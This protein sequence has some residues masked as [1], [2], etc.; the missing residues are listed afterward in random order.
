MPSPARF[1]GIAPLAA[2]RLVLI[3]A[4]SSM[5]AIF[6]DFA[7]FLNLGRK[8][9]RAMA[10][11]VER[12]TGRPLEAFVASPE[13]ALTTAADAAHPRARRSRSVGRSRADL[14]GGRRAYQAALGRRTRPS[15]HPRRSGRGQARRIVPVRADR[16][17][18]GCLTGLPL[19]P[20]V[21]ATMSRLSRFVRHGRSARSE[22]M[23]TPDKQWSQQKDK[24][25][26]KAERDKLRKQ[27]RAAAGARSVAA[28]SKASRRQASR[29]HGPQAAARTRPRLRS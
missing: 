7:R 2:E 11:Q 3:A 5:P 22:L 9:Y 15:P 18:P 19:R 6:E 20:R 10:S 26:N 27:E 28:R 21:P 25:R 8:S 17:G 1:E 16:A 23:K 24:D 14:R 29:R 12:I 13:F 4:P